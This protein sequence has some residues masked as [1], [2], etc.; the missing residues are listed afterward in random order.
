MSGPHH[1]L[2]T[3]DTTDEDNVSGGYSFLFG[4]TLKA[5]GHHIAILEPYHKNSPDMPFT[6]LHQQPPRFTSPQN[7]VAPA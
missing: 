6:C 4:E 1:H 5:V 3:I 7:I 2:A